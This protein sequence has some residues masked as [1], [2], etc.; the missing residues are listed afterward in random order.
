MPIALTM[1]ETPMVLIAAT[2]RGGASRAAGLLDTMRKIP[3]P[4]PPTLNACFYAQISTRLSLNHLGD[5]FVHPKKHRSKHA[6]IVC[7]GYVARSLFLRIYTYP[8]H[9]HFTMETAY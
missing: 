2:L 8:L 5:I 9:C 4:P 7:F 6:V 3:P 1:A